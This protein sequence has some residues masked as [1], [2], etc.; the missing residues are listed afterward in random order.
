MSVVKLPHL[1][2]LEQ[3]IMPRRRI[4]SILKNLQ[5]SDNSSYIRLFFHADACVLD[6]RMEIYKDCVKKFSFTDFKMDLPFPCRGCDGYQLYY[7]QQYGDGNSPEAMSC[8]KVV[9]AINDHEHHDKLVEI[10]VAKC[11]E[12]SD[13]NVGIGPFGSHFFAATATV[14]GN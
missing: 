14:G 10:D 4:L 11:D 7:H 6:E 1:R 9:T 13:L 2:L 12:Q 5:F 3:S 8:E